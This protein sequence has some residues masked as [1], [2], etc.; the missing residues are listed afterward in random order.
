VSRA[1]AALAALL[2]A[3]C[4]RPRP[5]PPP[6]PPGPPGPPRPPIVV[7]PPARTPPRIS[8]QRVA[9]A[10]DVPATPP[11][12][13]T[14]RIHLIDVGTGLALLVQGA[15]FALL[16][17]AGTSDPDEKPLRVVAYLAAALGPSGDDECSEAGT[18]AAGRRRIDHVVLSH[19]HQDHASALELVLHCFAVADV[20]D[21]GVVRD[22]A[23]YRDL[24]VAVAHAAGATYH[25]AAEPSRDRT[26]TV[27]DQ[28]VVLP[29]S[30]QWLSFRE[31]DRV[32]LGEDAGFEV[33]H[34][35]GK[36]HAD[37]N[38]ESIVL[39]VRLG[40]TRLLLTGDAESGPRADPSAPLGDVEAHLVAHF[41]PE[42]DADIL[43][44]GHHGSLTS[45]RRELLAA[46]TPQLALVSAGPKLFGRVR[47][48]D[49]AIID[50]LLAS[51]ATVLRTDEHDGACP[52][53]ERIGAERGPGGCDSYVI[54]IDDR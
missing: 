22:T 11:A 50:E 26:I 47:L 46:V 34:A 40:R 45:T 49:A 48:P 41:R 10:A 54:T 21:A 30:V 44:V 23:F 25:T 43:Q 14:W 51:G 52:L 5:A 32:V 2:L 37:A 29:P 27:R 6:Q 35:E 15:D 24:V 16:Y 31:G 17:D 33:L 3:A 7:E 18:A 13:G 8:W 42:L 36:A 1:F 12:P 53:A 39:A 9:T 28:A 38:Q 4:P 20:W 19:P